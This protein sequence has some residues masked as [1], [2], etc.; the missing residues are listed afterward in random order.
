MVSELAT[1]PK[2]V[3]E[4]SWGNDVLGIY[5]SI[6]APSIIVQT[7]GSFLFNPVIPALAEDLK[8]GETKR[9]FGRGLNYMGLITAM[10]VVCVAVLD[11]VDRH[12][13]F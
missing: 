4:S 1:I 2:T 9:F 6:A 7:A 13:R 5:G 3:L 12:E 11:A 10:T 8:Q